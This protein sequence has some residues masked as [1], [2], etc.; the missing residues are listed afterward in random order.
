MINRHKFHNTMANYETTEVGICSNT[1]KI[2]A[3][4]INEPEFMQMLPVVIT[5]LIS[6]HF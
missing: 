2:T 6:I 4:K 1:K 5:V 3:I